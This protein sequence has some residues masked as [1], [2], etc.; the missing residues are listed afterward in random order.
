MLA[1]VEAGRKPATTGNI[2][3][4]TERNLVF[5]D[6]QVE[7]SGQFPG[8]IVAEFA[9]NKPLNL[10]QHRLLGGQQYRATRRAA[11][12]QCSLRTLQNLNILQIIKLCVVAKIGDAEIWDFVGI[13]NYAGLC[14]KGR[15][16]AAQEEPAIGTLRAIRTDLQAGRMRNEIILIVNAFFAKRF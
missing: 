13:D 2:S 14:A 9:F 12:E 10:A 3:S 5:K 11:S 7:S 4:D 1:R 8:C 6:R 16:L 15:T